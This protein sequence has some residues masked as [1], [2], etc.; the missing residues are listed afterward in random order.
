MH[1]PMTFEARLA[2]AYGRYADGADVDVAAL[3]LAA[4]IATW[5]VSARSPDGAVMAALGESDG[6]GGA[7]A[8][9]LT[10]VWNDVPTRSLGPAP[11]PG[12]PLAE[13]SNVPC[14]QWLPEVS[15]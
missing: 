11:G 1:D 7:R 2:E 12:A 14:L 8:L 5:N 10:D 3:D 4:A 9:F 13:A 15:Q 6:F